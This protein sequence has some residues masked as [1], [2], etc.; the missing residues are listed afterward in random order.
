MTTQPSSLERTLRAAL[1]PAM[2]AKDTVAVAALRSAL[3]A[4]ANAEAVDPSVAEVGVRAAGSS[5][6]VAGALVG[7]GAAEVARRQLSD[8]DVRR[9][10]VD[11]VTSREVDADTLERHGATE[12][13]ST[14]RAEAEVLS[15]VLRHVPVV[16]DRAT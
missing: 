14:L 1:V 16:P 11:E 4:I 9:I 15:A 5:E 6:H 10:V 8:D 3:A 7:L 2:R 12:R 13:A